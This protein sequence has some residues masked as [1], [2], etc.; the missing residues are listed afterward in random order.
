MNTEQNDVYTKITNHIVEAIERGLVEGMSGEKAWRM[1]WHVSAD[2]SFPTNAASE[3]PYRGVNVLT[4]WATADERDYSSGLWATY[5]QWRDFGAQ[6]RKGEKGSPVVFWKTARQEEEE[7]G[8][9]EEESM[10]RPKMFARAYSV[11]NL[12]QVDGYEP[13]PMPTLSEDERIERADEFFADLG[14]EIHH[15]GIQ[16]YYSPTSD[17]IQM[18]PF[19]AFKEPGGYYAVLAH[20]ATH[21]TGAG[22]RLN[23][24][25]SGRFKSEAYAVEELI[26]ELGAAFVCA[27]LGLG[28]QPRQD[29]AAY[30][31]GWLRVLKADRRAI[32]TAASKAQQAADW[33]QNRAA[34]LRP[35]A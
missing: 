35:V 16:A 17:H 20:E 10:A 12:D 5:K 26:A 4:L 1:P 3:Q 19:A 31:A 30:L 2:C 18:P 34:E 33:M 14:P 9:G 23:R 21:W 25:L 15:G 11:F 6:V 32:F 22:H 27:V 13:Q 24:Q 7:A 29:H 8:Q 28:T